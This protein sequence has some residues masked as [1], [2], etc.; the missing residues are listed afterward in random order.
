METEMFSAGSSRVLEE[1][2]ARSVRT[3]WQRLADSADAPLSNWL[4]AEH[5][6]VACLVVSKL[7]SSCA[8][9][10]HTRNGCWARRR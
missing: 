10:A 7:R 8:P 2:D 9:A 6:Q 3:I 1:I 4:S 5:P